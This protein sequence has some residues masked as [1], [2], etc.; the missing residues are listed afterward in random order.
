MKVTRY[1]ESKPITEI[2]GVSRRDALT[3][4]DGASHFTMH[5]MEIT[6]HASTPT[7]YH[8][9]EHEILVIDGK[10]IVVGE[11]GGTPIAEGS[12]VFIPGNETHCFVNTGDETLRYVNIE[13]IKEAVEK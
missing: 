1:S 13:P 11:K 2:E 3:A 9:F 6:T 4:K 8:P 12:V 5:I 10:G 7:H